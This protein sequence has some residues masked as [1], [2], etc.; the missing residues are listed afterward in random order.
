MYE[1]PNC[2]GNLKFDIPSQQLMCLHCST[3]MDPYAFQK[4]KDVNEDEF[5]DVTVFTC[6]QCA[7]EI[8]SEDNEA[9]AFCSFCGASTILDSRLTQKRRPEYIIPFKKT[10]GDCKQ[11][12]TKMLKKAFFAPD[13]L[14]NER[15]INSFRGIYMPYWTYKVSQRGQFSLLGTK[16]YRRGD[17]I[18]HDHYDLTGQIDALYDG[19]SFDASSTFADNLSQSISPFNVSDMKEFTPSFL[20]GF[21]ADVADTSAGLYQEDAAAVAGRESFE[22][23]KKL[24]VFRPYTVVTP[25]TDYKIANRMNT[26][27]DAATATMFP[28]WFLSYRNGDRVAYA[29]VNGQTGK[30]A[31]DLPVDP[32]KYVKGSLLLA[33]P[34]FVLL[35]FAF[36]IIPSVLIMIAAILGIITLL[37]YSQGLKELV[38]KERNLDDKGAMFKGNTPPLMSEKPRKKKGAIM[39]TIAVILF[40]AIYFGPM[41]YNIDSRILWAIP[42]V[43]GAIVAY[44]T[45]QSLKQLHTNKRII[46]FTGGILSIAI[47]CGIGILNPVSDAYYYAGTLTSLIALFWAIGDLI[48]YYNMLTTRKLPQFNRQGGDDRA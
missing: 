9:A 30:V 12:Y 14:K 23:A 6:P 3:Q 15:Y 28:V 19:L 5:F 47:A 17:Y 7:G 31:A 11:A 43:V 2:N 32:G 37:I 33:I 44:N 48:H 21:Y 20:S 40:F 18:Y 27:C 1:C 46:G 35:N 25:D 45:Y 42:V 8:I 29:T 22:R 24:P 26:Y 38:R 16:D 10:K 41:L 34:I 39:S 4:E 36:T 13:E